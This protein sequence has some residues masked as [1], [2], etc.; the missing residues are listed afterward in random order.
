MGE[1]QREHEMEEVAQAFSEGLIAA[2]RISSRPDW[3]ARQADPELSRRFYDLV[4]S[5]LEARAAPTR[6]NQDSTARPEEE[7]SELLDYYGSIQPVRAYMEFLSSMVA[8]S[9]ESAMRMGSVE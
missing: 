6:D 3:V 8:H 1:E 2:Y 5:Q 9:M 7:P 4:I